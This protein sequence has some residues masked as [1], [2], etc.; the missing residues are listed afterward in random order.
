M[1]A[2]EIGTFSRAKEASVLKEEV[3]PVSPGRT[4]LA[5]FLSAQGHIPEGP[6]D[7]TGSV[8]PVN[9]ETPPAAAIDPGISEKAFEEALAA[10][11]KAPELT[12]EDRLS[13]VGVTL[14]KAQSIVDAIL[15]RNTYD[16]TYPLTSKIS[17]TFRTRLVS[18]NDALF[19]SLEDKRPGYTI[20]LSN[21]ITKHNLAA[22]LSVVGKQVFPATPEGHTKAMEGSHPRQLP[23]RA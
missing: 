17:V 3:K 13:K 15:T 14:E 19:T 18:N 1:A 20:T 22:S 8:Q 16:E 4:A 12:Y 7:P 23:L 9:P 21:H 11:A 10:A 2:P 5:E 6:V